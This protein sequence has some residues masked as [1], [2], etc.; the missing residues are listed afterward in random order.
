LAV[1][2]AVDGGEDFEFIYVN[3][4][5]ERLEGLSREG[6]L[7]KR[8]TE[9]FPGVGEMGLLDALRRVYQTKKPEHLA[10][11]LY[12]DQL[13]AG[14]SVNY[15]LPLDSGEVVVV[16][17]RGDP[18]GPN[19]LQS[20]H[21]YTVEITRAPNLAEVAEKTVEALREVLGYTWAEF[22]VVEKD[23]LRSLVTLGA[24][25]DTSFSIGLNQ[26][27][28]V[29]RAVKTGETQ[30]VPDTR[31]DPDYLA[32]DAS[33][34]LL[35][36]LAM[37]V[38]VGGEVR[39]VIN[40]EDEKPGAFTELDQIYVETLAGYVSSALE[41]L[42]ALEDE[43]RHSQRLTALNKATERLSKARSVEELL[44]AA[45]A[46]MVKDFGYAWVGVAEVGDEGVKYTAST[47]RDVVDRFY[48]FEELGVIP[49]A[50]KTGEPQLVHDTRLEPGYV[51]I[52]D[53]PEMLSELAVPVTVG[54]RVAM[55]LNLESTKPHDFSERD[56]V[57]ME[58][59]ARHLSENLKRLRAEREARQYTERLE[60]LS[61]AMAE[62]NKAGSVEALADV[63]LRLAS[64][65]IGVPYSSFLLVKDGILETISTRSV[66][67]Q[68]MRL[69][70]DGN[71][72]T[73]R[74][75]REGKPIVVEDTRLD[76]CFVKGSIDSLSELAVPM[77]VGGE[78]VGVLN[79]ESLEP[80]Y[81][82]QHHVNLMEALA[83]H[84]A[85]N[86]E[87]LRKT[88][89]AQEAE[90][91]SELKNIF[92]QTA[93]HELRT[94]LT[95][96]LG[97]LELIREKPL[98]G[99]AA[100]YL[101]VVERNAQRLKKLTDDL[102][103]QQRLESGK[104]KLWTSKQG[105]NRLVEQATSEM[106]PLLEKRGQELAVDVP[107]E[108]LMVEVDGVRVLQ[109]LVN[110]LS[111]ASKY[112]PEGGRIRVRVADGGE[113]VVVSVENEGM[114]IKPEDMPKLFKP[115]PGIRVPGVKDSVGLG[116]SICRGIVELHGGRIWAESEGPGKGARFTFTLSKAEL[117][118]DG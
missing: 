14:W 58:L 31:L 27:N 39:A 49:R 25:E 103:E 87:R 76:P 65:I 57:L 101:E 45:M 40:I 82:N 74:V 83:A 29:V 96:I 28:V 7:G 77:F 1:L 61:Q 109:V 111:N 46:V 59:L 17:R 92:M 91:L 2:R 10:E 71:G 21:Q 3:N 8:L 11:A 93:T 42:E 105:I 53:S 110:L 32:I 64:E 98:P 54:G 35:S 18:L 67:K 47:S 56:V 102:V 90:R 26:R 51:A 107:G 97:Y 16:H 88:R 114:G 94:P 38:K 99:K 85:S 41:R 89:E 116:L 95:S 43:E 12:R 79:A 80:G 106:K 118:D 84:A 19:Y 23:R 44:E 13:R 48:G 100:R 73:V 24:H 22:M 117:A 81:F 69:P 33:A 60:R 115:F 68:F 52:E 62:M 55:V 78:V 70:L 108:D 86:L 113:E 9:A 6:V 36:E 15:I 30:L 4:N 37:P 63:T 66:P 50:V 34:E 112:S 5:V 72:V 104:V 75:V 20:L